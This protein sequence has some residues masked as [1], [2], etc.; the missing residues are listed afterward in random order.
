MSIEEWDGL[1]EPSSLTVEQ[2]DDL[3]RKLRD[4]RD[5]YDAKKKAS[6]EAHAALEEVEK[7]VINT[8]QAAKKS[9]YELPGVA[10]VSISHKE[11][12]TTPKTNDDKNKLFSYIKEKYGPDALMAMVGINSQTLNAW[13]NKES[14]AGVMVIPG[15]AAPTATETL[16]MRRK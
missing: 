2:L 3:I 4:A 6:S 1:E 8:L 12:Y 11:S 16:S 10:L 5:E 7:L 14:E 9:K 15:L 13:A